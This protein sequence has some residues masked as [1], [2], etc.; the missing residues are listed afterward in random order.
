MTLSNLRDL[1]FGRSPSD[2]LVH[3][4]LN[5]LVDKVQKLK[6]QPFDPEKDIYYCFLDVIFQ[7]VY[8]RQINDNE[9][10]VQHIPH[11]IH[12]VNQMFWSLTACPALRY[13]PFYQRLIKV[14]MAHTQYV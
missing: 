5:L 13:L 6:G 9:P 8:G 3:E 7:L 12:V 10:L 11:L 2:F 14:Y 1:G 4:S